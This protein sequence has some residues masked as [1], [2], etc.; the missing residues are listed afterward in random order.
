MGDSLRFKVFA[1][2]I[3]T[4]FPKVKSIAD[5]A[6]GKGC[7]QVEL[8]KL[9]YTVTTYDK[10]H[11][12]ISRNLSY[13]YAYF[14]NRVKDHYDLL[15]G[16]H[17]DEATD[18][19]VTEAIKRNIPFCVVP[20][21][22]IPHATKCNKKV[23]IEKDSN[24]LYWFQSLEYFLLDYKKWLLEFTDKK[25]YIKNIGINNATWN[26]YINEKCKKHGINNKIFFKDSI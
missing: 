21:C 7:L 9:G 14:D 3:K 22:V 8:R 25:I 19:I 1:N 20:C 17:P 13:K 12:R 10:R 15:I 2:Y 11:V 4:N 18:V 16:M 24:C 6:G 23:F 26:C 5:I